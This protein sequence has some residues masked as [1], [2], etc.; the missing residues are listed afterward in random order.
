MK[1]LPYTQVVS[2][3]WGAW[4]SGMVNKSLKEQFSKRG[5]E[6]LSI[7]DGVNLFWHILSSGEKGVV[8]ADHS[9]NLTKRFMEHGHAN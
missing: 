1:S 5:I 2:I 4:D 6:L 8:I 9:K 7:Q 3:C